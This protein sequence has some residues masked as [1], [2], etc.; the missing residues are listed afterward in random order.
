MR[1]SQDSTAYDGLTAD[2]KAF[3][4]LAWVQLITIATNKSIMFACCE[5]ALVVG[6]GVSIRLIRVELLDGG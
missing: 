2:N 1:R 3:T 5:N 4:S 6:I